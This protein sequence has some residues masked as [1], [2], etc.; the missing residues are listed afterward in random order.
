ML[1]CHLP[2]AVRG[3]GS[4]QG[5][6]GI[7]VRYVSGLQ[8]DNDAVMT[9]WEPTPAELEALNQGAKIYLTILGERQPPM[10]LTVGEPPT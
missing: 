1:N 6:H 2:G 7:S 9:C 3:V 10:L 8:G 5:Y 4:S